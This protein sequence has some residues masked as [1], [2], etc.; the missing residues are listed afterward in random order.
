VDA[1]AALLDGDAELLE[2]QLAL[3]AVEAECAMSA[4]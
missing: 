4:F 3:F 2:R 1:D